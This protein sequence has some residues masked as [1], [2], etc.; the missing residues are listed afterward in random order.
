M[1][2]LLTHW[3]QS[4]IAGEIIRAIRNEA[5]GRQQLVAR[6]L[7]GISYTARPASHHLWLPLPG[8]LSGPDLLSYLMRRGVAVVGEDAF[9]VGDS[10]PRGIR[11]SLGAARNRSELTQA[12]HILSGAM[13][14]SE[15]VQVV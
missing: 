13:K 3:I 9:A 6:L 4:G 14:S 15:I 11:V 7:K 10:A 5:M 12:L 8:H 2:A 1:V